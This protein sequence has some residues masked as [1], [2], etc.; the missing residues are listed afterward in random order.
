MKPCGN[1]NERLIYLIKF[2]DNSAY[3]GLTGDIERRK[4]EH[5]HAQKRNTAVYKY[6][7][8]TELIPELI[9][10]TN[11]LDVE[12]AIKMEKYY[13]Q[14]YKDKGFKLINNDKGGTIGYGGKD[15]DHKKYKRKK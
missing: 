12:E 9:Q 11:Y 8:E 15:W 5:L 3:I 10:L 1:L 4:Y 2:S 13:I 6:A 7:L 14:Y